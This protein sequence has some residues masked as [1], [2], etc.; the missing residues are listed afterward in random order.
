VRC[1]LHEELAANHYTDPKGRPKT[2]RWWRMSVVEDLG[3]HADDEV[4]GLRWL[5]PDDALA[6]LSY[7][8]DRSLVAGHR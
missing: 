8:H 2:V 3:F 4:D 1:A 6:L 7:D 5:R